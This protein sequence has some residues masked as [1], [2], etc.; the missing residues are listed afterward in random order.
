MTPEFFCQWLAEMKSE[1]LARSDAECARLLERDVSNIV[2]MKKR[3]A[4]KVVALACRVLS[5]NEL[6][7]M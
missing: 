3:G 6:V 5:R 4:D 7:K 1:N 2:R